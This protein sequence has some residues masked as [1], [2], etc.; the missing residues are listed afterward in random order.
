MSDI[1]QAI[2]HMKNSVQS[3]KNNL[4]EI[5]TVNHINMDWDGVSAMGQPISI[6]DKKYF[7][8][9]KGIEACETAITALQE[10]LEREK[11]CS[12]CNNSECAAAGSSYHCETICEECR[13]NLKDK[14]FCPMC[15]RKLKGSDQHE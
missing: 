7:F 9:V 8:S 4:R 10:K 11:G 5:A 6:E 13:F 15:G 14:N 3:Y 12:W 2:Q 1:E